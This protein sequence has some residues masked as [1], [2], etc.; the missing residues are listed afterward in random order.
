MERL[1]PLP[2]PPGAGE[3]FFLASSRGRQAGRSRR[4]GVEGSLGAADRATVA[5]SAH[6]GKIVAKRVTSRERVPAGDEDPLSVVLPA[7]LKL[8]VQAEAKKR[9]MDLS[10]A[11]RVLLRERVEEL[12]DDTQLRQAETWQRAQAWATWEKIKAGD[13]REVSKAE[14]DADFDDALRRLAGP[15]SQ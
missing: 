6:Q 14:L 13:L 15:R 5:G 1:G 10:Q 7:D 2:P 4:D 8:R 12:E 11:V 3:T 9:D